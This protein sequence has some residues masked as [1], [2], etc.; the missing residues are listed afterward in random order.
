MTP[1]AHH[2]PSPPAG[3]SYLDFPRGG[4]AVPVLGSH[5]HCNSCT[6]TFVALTLLLVKSEATWRSNWGLL[7]GA[8]AETPP[9]KGGPE[10]PV[11]LEVDSEVRFRQGPLSMER[12]Q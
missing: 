12:G 1:S 3:C 4:L 10:N 9:Q 5:E 6:M 11:Q 7:A 8:G 2:A